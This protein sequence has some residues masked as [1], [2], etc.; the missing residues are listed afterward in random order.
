M[1][2][3]LPGNAVETPIALEINANHRYRAEEMGVIEFRIRNQGPDRIRTLDLLLTCPCEKSGKKSALVK[4][5]L[6]AA[7]KKLSFQFDPARGGEALIEVAISLE[8][9]SRR[10]M[11]FRGQTSVTISS[12]NEGSSSH[13]SFTLDIHDIDKFMGNDL[14]ELLGGAGKDREIDAARLHQRM[15]RKDPFWM[16]V[17][18]DLDEEET[19][20]QRD[21]LRQIIAPVSGQ[22][23][24]RTSKA[25]LE[26]LNPKAPRRAFL[27]SLPE[28]IFGREPQRSDAVLR[29]LP[30]FD[31][32]PRS[33]TI[34]A[35]QLVVRCQGSECTL[36]MA[37]NAHQLMSVNHRLLKEAEQIPLSGAA[38]IKIGPCEM[39]LKFAAVPNHEDAHWQR[40][41]EEIMQ[42]DPGPDPFSAAPWDMVAFS[43]PANGKEE[44]YI[45]LLRQMEIGWIS[46]SEAELQ[47]GWPMKPRAR[48][49][50]WSGRYYL[51]ALGVEKEIQAGNAPI[52]PGKIRCLEPDMEIGFGSLRFLWRLL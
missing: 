12:K 20:R 29:F 1:D 5:L 7:E 46:G 40:T 23:P 4:S 50:F 45:W 48:L 37:P 14:S 52:P 36:G 28:V 35:E 34:S 44:E 39:T 43:R 10:P 30:D 24:F 6:P 25:L 19:A 15:E 8:D 3:Y 38:E 16:R 32:D 42:F 9:E 26:S 27:Y 17:D 41:R 33:R 49:I 13:T 21:A 47:L 22:M 11:V 18:L 31:N 2:E 51:E